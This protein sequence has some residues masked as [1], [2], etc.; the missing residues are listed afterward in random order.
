M[1]PLSCYCYNGGYITTS[2]NEKIPICFSNDD[3]DVPCKN[4]EV[5]GN[6]KSIKIQ[7]DS[8]NPCPSGEMNIFFV[9]KYTC[10]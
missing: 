6:Y 7:P 5:S 9:T 2:S 10:K 8:N 4:L 1:D 3:E